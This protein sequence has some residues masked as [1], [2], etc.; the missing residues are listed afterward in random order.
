MDVEGRFSPQPRHRTNEIGH[1]L[2]RGERP[3][4][5]E[6]HRPA[7]RA[8]VG[9]RTGWRV[10]DGQHLPERI[11]PAH[12]APHLVAHDEHRIGARREPPLTGEQSPALA[13][14]HAEVRIIEEARPH[15]VAVENERHT[16]PLGR[17]GRDAERWK[18]D[19]LDDVR[20]GR[21]DRVAQ[22]SLAARPQAHLGEPAKR[23]V[24]GTADEPHGVSAPSDRAERHRLDSEVCG[25]KS[26]GCAFLEP[27]EHHL[28]AGVTYASGLLHRSRES[29][30]VLRRHVADRGPAERSGALRHRA[31][32]PRSWRSNRR[33]P[34][35]R[36]PRACAGTRHRRRA[37]GS[38]WR[39]PT[40]PRC[41]RS[42]RR[43]ARR[44]PGTR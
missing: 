32:P 6:T 41:R 11:A 42:R 27:A 28:G 1:V 26:G 34:S 24:A 21:D 19:S 4:E 31:A 39:R 14:G 8:N 15:L 10:E 7:G 23:P 2:R 43:C 13:R 30:E 22:R 9:D 18:V 3:V 5:D 36:K 35:A 40:P 29:G 44:V 17:S 16:H 38:P 12:P 20:A 37:R 33:H 25:R